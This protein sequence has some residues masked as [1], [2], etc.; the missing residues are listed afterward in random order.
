MPSKKKCAC[1]FF[2]PKHHICVECQHCATSSG[3]IPDAIAALPQCFH[4]MYHRAPYFLTREA[5]SELAGG[6]ISP[7]T[8]ANRDALGIGPKKSSIFNRKVVYP[9]EEG[10]FWLAKFYKEQ[11][12]EHE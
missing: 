10:I 1:H 12:G 3:Y 2:D 9:R 4:K 7:K 6:A 5:L 8:L 11:G